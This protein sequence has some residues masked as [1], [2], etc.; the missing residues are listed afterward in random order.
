MKRR[1]REN[2]KGIIARKLSNQKSSKKTGERE[3]KEEKEKEEK[4][5][6]PK[7]KNCVNQGVGG[8]KEGKLRETYAETGGQKRRKK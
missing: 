7:S 5:T 8:N 2:K 1:E 4:K 6:N 3:R